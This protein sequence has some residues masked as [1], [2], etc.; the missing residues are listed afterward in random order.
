MSDIS[1]DLLIS[2][3]LLSSHISRSVQEL[4]RSGSLVTKQKVSMIFE[5]MLAVTIFILAVTARPAEGGTKVFLV[6]GSYYNDYNDYDGFYAEDDAGSHFKR[7]GLANKRGYHMYLWQDGARWKLGYGETFSKEGNSVRLYAAGGQQDAPPTSG[8]KDWWF[9]SSRPDI[10]VEPVPSL[11]LPSS[12]AE[13]EGGSL[14][15]EDGV[16]CKNQQE[17]WIH[18]TKDQ[19]CDDKKIHC[20]NHLDQLLCLEST[21]ESTLKKTV[22]EEGSFK[23]DGGVLSVPK[24]N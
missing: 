23:T 17:T 12:Q 21:L 11:V 7:L 10:R 16:M 15:T 6:I 20:K 4:S 2:H 8:W 13:A 3:Q 24:I 14:T 5:K 1:L 18:V 22:E 9:G 19:V